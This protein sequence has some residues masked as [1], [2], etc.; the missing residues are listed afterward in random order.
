MTANHTSP[1]IDCGGRFPLA[2]H[3]DT[4][5]TSL[6]YDDRVPFDPMARA[7]T[8]CVLPFGNCSTVD[9]EEASTVAVL[10]YIFGVVPHSSE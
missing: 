9:R 6:L 8:N 2:L 10:R 3:D 4:T 1:P 7:A 5:R